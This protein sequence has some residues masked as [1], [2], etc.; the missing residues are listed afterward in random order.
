MNCPE[1]LV[2]KAFR[3]HLWVWVYWH[4]VPR[5]TIPLRVWLNPLRYEVTA[6]A[7]G[8]TWTI[9]RYGLPAQNAAYKLRIKLERI[10]WRHS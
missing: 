7:F 6:R 8:K 10:F 5:E 4:D 1:H 2:L 9:N 3:G